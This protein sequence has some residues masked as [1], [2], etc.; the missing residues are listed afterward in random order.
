MKPMSEWTDKELR[1]AVNAAPHLNKDDSIN[2]AVWLGC[3]AKDELE[4]RAKTKRP[5]SDLA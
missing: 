1:A 4:K 5:M 2:M 3:H